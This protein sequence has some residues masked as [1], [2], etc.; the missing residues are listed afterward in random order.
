MEKEGKREERREEN[1]LDRA[2]AR[3][4]LAVAHSQQ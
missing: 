2:R 4:F 1:V 3:S